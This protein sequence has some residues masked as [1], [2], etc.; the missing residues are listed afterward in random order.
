M[1][2]GPYGRSR[3]RAEKRDAGRRKGSIGTET[4]DS[5]IYDK[6]REE[7]SL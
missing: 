4:F 2:V 5:K 3:E 6:S 1:G 7:R